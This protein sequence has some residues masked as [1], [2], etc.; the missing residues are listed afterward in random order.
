LFKHSSY[1]LEEEV[2]FVLRINPK[3][4][5]LGKGVIIKIAAN[6]FID[7]FRVSDAILNIE[8]ECVEVLAKAKLSKDTELSN[9]FHKNMAALE[10][11]SSYHEPPGVFQDLD[12][13]P[14]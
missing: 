7:W 5:S 9:K 12:E 8:K 4:T 11:F 13:P 10:P 6:D 3:A 2:R 14:P 1:H